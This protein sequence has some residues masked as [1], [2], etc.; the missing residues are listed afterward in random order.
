MRILIVLV[1]GF[2][3]L[4]LG[5]V[6]EPLHTLGTL[7]PETDMCIEMGSIGEALVPSAAGF[8]VACPLSLSEILRALVG[9]G[10]PD[11]LFLCCGLRTPYKSQGD[12]QKLLR[13]AHRSGVPILGTG[14]AAW[15]MADA[16]ILHQ[17][18]GTVHWTTLPA[19]AERH[20]DIA[21]RDAL[22]VTSDHATSTPG[23]AA[24][25]DMVIAFIKQRFS[26][27]LAQQ[28]CNHLM[29]NYPRP[30]DANQ[31]RG[32][33]EQLRGAPQK[34]RQ[35]A[36]VMAE[37]LESPLLVR[38]IAAAIGLSLRQTERLFAAHLGQSP[39]AYYLTLRLQHGRM[40]IEQTSM[41]ILEISIATGFS[42]RRIFTQF[43]RGEFGFPPSHTR[44]TP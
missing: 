30:G 40:L 11:A 8:S 25:L 21:A 6:L 22:F 39:K 31:P 29:I 24:A 12:I 5:A 7:A 34:L 10:R 37:N 13:T 20:H 14:C 15:K 1:P 27:D 32:Q 28:V 4:S 43:Y 23:D 41:T 17:G 26:A 2:S 18:A 33:V 19:F 9:A 35:I 3:H 44:R 38:D 16:G 42:S 36:Q